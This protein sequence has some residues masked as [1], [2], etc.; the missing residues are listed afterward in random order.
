MEFAQVS[1]SIDLIISGHGDA[2]SPELRIV[3]N[4][5]KEEV[6]V[7]HGAPQGILVKQITIGFDE[8]QVKNKI[9]YRNIVPGADRSLSGYQ[10]VKR[11]T[12]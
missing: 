5:R 7:S 12:A 4:K 6:M 1:E 8:R 10:E 9:A 2:V 11:I 3:R